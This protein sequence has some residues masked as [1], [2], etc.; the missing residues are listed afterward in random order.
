MAISG[1]G[2]MQEK[3]LPATVCSSC[4]NVTVPQRVRTYHTSCNASNMR[5]QLLTVLIVY[6][7]NLKSYHGCKENITIPYTERGTSLFPRFH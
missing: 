6:E 5:L 4:R 2:G 7:Q 3:C 1:A